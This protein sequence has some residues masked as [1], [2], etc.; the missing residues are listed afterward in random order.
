MEEPPTEYDGE[1]KEF[2]WHTENAQGYSALTMV[3]GEDELIVVMEYKDMPNP[4]KLAWE[5]LRDRCVQ[6]LHLHRLEVRNRLVELRME[7]GE[8]LERYLTQ[9]DALTRS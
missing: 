8:I 6:K 1:E 5:K 7:D 2:K 3:L 4:A 9:C